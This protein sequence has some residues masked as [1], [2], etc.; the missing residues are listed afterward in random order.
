MDEQTCD[1]KREKVSFTGLVMK[2][3]W[4]TIVQT[5]RDSFGGRPNTVLYPRERLVLP[6]RYRGKHVLSFKRCIGCGQCVEICPN[7]CMWMKRID[8]PVLGKIERPGVD[9]SRC[10]FCGLCAEICPT[11]ALLMTSEYELSTSERDGMRYEPEA[12]RNDEYPVK[13]PK[14]SLLIPVLGL[15]KCKGK[16]AC[17]KVCP[18]KCIKMVD[19]DRTGKR[20]PEI[21]LSICIH[22][23]KCAE[24]CPEKAFGM[25]PK[26]VV[27]FERPLPLFNLDKCTGCGACF[28]ACPA[29]VIYMMEMP[30][31][32]KK[33]A[34]GTMTKPKKRAV[35]VLE[36]C[37][38]CGRC[39]RACRFE[40]LEMVPESQYKSAKP[41]VAK[42]PKKGGKKK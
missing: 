39:E 18:V 22:C 31:T 37:I 28:R 7:E 10:L 34:D 24:A 12:L 27:M 6:D 17:V 21:D 32:E 8:D 4:A 11:D 38:G 20:K 29:D 42:G 35:F 19:I 30:G 33:K 1:K 36:K 9:Y 13:E 5:A 26:L 3:I 15:D 16:E 2:P 23:G 41:S 14:E 40:T 25:Q